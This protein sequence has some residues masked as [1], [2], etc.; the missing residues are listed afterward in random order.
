MAIWRPTPHGPTLQVIGGVAVRPRHRGAL[1]AARAATCRALRQPQQPLPPVCER[2]RDTSPADRARE[3]SRQ[4]Q[5]AIHGRSVA[6]RR[7]AAPGVTVQIGTASLVGPG[8]SKAVVRTRAAALAI[9]AAAAAGVAPKAAPC[10]VASVI[11]GK[12]R[13][14]TVR[15]KLPRCA[16]AGRLKPSA[17]RSRQPPPSLKPPSP[18]RLWRGGRPCSSPLS[19]W[20]PRPGPPGAPSAMCKLSDHACNALRT[21]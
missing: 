16:A 12:P 6:G 10:R 3:G 8:P 11:Q 18:S 20:K 21:R 13:E 9:A 1:Q 4:T 19:P 14:G 5:S 17:F 15:D 7:P 2:Y